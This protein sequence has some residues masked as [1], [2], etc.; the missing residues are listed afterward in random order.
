MQRS[1]AKT[2]QKIKNK[3][4]LCRCKKINIKFIYFSKFK[5]FIRKTPKFGIEN[6]LKCNKKF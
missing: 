1:S 6:F 3:I 4:E 2:K 5:I